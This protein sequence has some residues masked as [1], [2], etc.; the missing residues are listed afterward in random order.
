[1]A[2]STWPSKN[3]VRAARLARIRPVTVVRIPWQSRRWASGSPPG[4]CG[5]VNSA[6]VRAT[7]W[8]VRDGPG[9][10][11]GRRF[12]N[13]QIISVSVLDLHSVP[14]PLWSAS[15]GT[16]YTASRRQPMARGDAEVREA[17]TALRRGTTRLA[18]RLRLERQQPRPAEPELSNLALSVL[19][20]LH[21]R[22]PATPGALAAA[23]RLQPQPLTRTLAGP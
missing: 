17:A 13:N 5:R 14:N 23:D 21:R 10:R 16:P 19:A 3:V 11:S 20:H 7:A 18:R 4:E 6:L 12:L 1:M 2:A 8:L 9:P 15:C 22:G